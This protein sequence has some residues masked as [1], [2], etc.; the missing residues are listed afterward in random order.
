MTW[1]TP[2]VVRVE[3]GAD[4]VVVEEAVAERRAVRVKPT[5]PP[6]R[7]KAKSF[8]C[9]LRDVGAVRA[10]DVGRVLQAGDGVGRVEADAERGLADRLD[11][12]DELGR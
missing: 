8:T 6:R 12:G 11:E 4:A 9:Q 1:L 7:V 10:I 2:R 5:Q 3:R